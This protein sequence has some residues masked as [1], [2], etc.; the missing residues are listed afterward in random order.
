MN[1]YVMRLK[2]G[3]LPGFPVLFVSS[4]KYLF[5]DL[6]FFVICQIFEFITTYE[7]LL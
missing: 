5:V 2:M 4:P 3:L 1:P 6:V 7:F